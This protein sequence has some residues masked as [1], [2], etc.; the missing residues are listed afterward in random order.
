MRNCLKKQKWWI[1]FAALLIISDAMFSACTAIILQKLFDLANNYKNKPQINLI[2]MLIGIVIYFSLAVLCFFLH[3]YMIH[4]VTCKIA[5]LY[6]ISVY[7]G[8]CKRDYKSFYDNSVSEYISNLT[9]E[10]NIITEDFILPI[11]EVFNNLVLSI[12]T[13]ILIV[14]YN[15]YI[16]IAMAVCLILILVIPNLFNNQI[17]K[18]KINYTDQL[19]NFTNEIN[20]TFSGYEILCSYN[21]LNNVMDNIVRRIGKLEKEHFKSQNIINIVS[22]LSFLLA[23]ITQIVIL[24]MGVYFIIQGKLTVGVV[25]ALIQLSGTFINPVISLVESYSRIKSAIP[26]IRKL[27][28]L[29]SVSLNSVTENAAPISFENT[30]KFDKL[31]FKY[32]GHDYT[33]KNI[34]LNIYKDKKYAIL[35]KNGCGKSTL[36][37]LMC[38]YFDDY[39]GNIY[40]DGTDFQKIDKKNI[41]KLIS[42]VHQ[43]IYLFNTSIKDNICMF[44]NYSDADL[45]RAIEISESNNFIQ[46]LNNGLF[47]IV[48]ENGGNFSGGQ[49]QRIA[50]ARAIIRKTPILILDESISAVDLKTGQEIENKLLNMKDITLLTV[51]HFL[52][53]KVL[54][55]YDFIIYMENGEISEIGSYEY[56]ISI[57]NKFYKYII[58]SQCL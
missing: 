10:I 30:I 34:S 44:E 58:E 25:V 4:K 29:A 54:K 56:L 39:E 20:D 5:E 52:D 6:R 12:S 8:I 23:N 53:K 28:K 14:Y 31:F 48:E 51:T 27:D 42:V 1:G 2:Y 21:A 55:K 15:K 35:G 49:K 11:F 36:L 24:F 45:R 13:G 46:R 9:N 26:I 32:T 47:S 40:I 17:E 37:K 41:N 16:A 7:S 18:R 38:G 33:I 43:N 19:S 3:K 22:S 50:L 57:K